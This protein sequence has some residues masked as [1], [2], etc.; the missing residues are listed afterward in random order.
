MGA[1]WPGLDL[2]PGVEM[3]VVGHSDSRATGHRL[4]PGRDDP[5]P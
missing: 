1:S 3:M 5:S 2:P 4:R